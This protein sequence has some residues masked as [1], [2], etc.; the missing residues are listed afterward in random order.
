MKLKIAKAIIKDLY[1]TKHGNSALISIED[2]D[3]IYT[4]SR[5]EV[6]EL[7]EAQKTE[8][9]TVERKGHAWDIQ[10]NADIQ[11]LPKMPTKSPLPFVPR[12]NFGQ[13]DDALVLDSETATETL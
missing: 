2:G 8:K 9:E 13:Y 4:I 11:T 1:E 3:V 10:A 6:A 7:L 5:V 12:E